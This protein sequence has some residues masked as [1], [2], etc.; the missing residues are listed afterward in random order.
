M[1]PINFSER[2]PELGR[3]RGQNVSEHGTFSTA[4]EV[5]KPR[6]S[7]STVLMRETVLVPI[8]NGI[9]QISRE[10]RR[11]DSGQSTPIAMVTNAPRATDPN[12][13]IGVSPKC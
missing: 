13:T 7:A 3:F 1:K 9:A 12:Q 5:V 11:L 4:E 6:N 2:W 10:K 8:G